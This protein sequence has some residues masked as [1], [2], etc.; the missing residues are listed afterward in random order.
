MQMKKLL[1]LLWMSL[2]QAAVNPR[3]Y[4]FSQTLWRAEA[5]PFLSLLRITCSWHFTFERLGML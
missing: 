3:L 5:T 1:Q 4:G 2:I